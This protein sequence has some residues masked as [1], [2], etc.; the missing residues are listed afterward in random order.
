MKIRGHLQQY[1]AE[2]N[3][4]EITEESSQHELEEDE[5]YFGL[6]CWETLKQKL[7]RIFEYPHT[8]VIAKECLKFSLLFKFKSYINTVYTVY[9]NFSRI[10]NSVDCSWFTLLT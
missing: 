1:F 4:K 7:W 3:E 6:G 8:S 2:A 9:I 10:S 5:R